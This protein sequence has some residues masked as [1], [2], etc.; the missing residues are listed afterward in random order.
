MSRYIRLLSIC[1][2]SALFI[3][4]AYVSAEEIPGIPYLKTAS[5]EQSAACP[6]K[7]SEQQSHV[8]AFSLL[9]PVVIDFTPPEVTETYPEEGELVRESRPTIRVCYRDENSLIDI[10]S[11][12]VFLDGTDMTRVSSISE[13]QL[14]FRPWDILQPGDHSITVILS[15]AVGN[16]SAPRTIH[17]MVDNTCTSSD[18]GLEPYPQ[19][20]NHPSDVN[21]GMFYDFQSKSNQTE[22][23][24]DADNTYIPLRHSNYWYVERNPDG[25]SSPSGNCLYRFK[26]EKLSGTMGTLS[27]PG[28]ELLNLSL[29]RPGLMLGTQIAGIKTQAFALQANPADPFKYS[30][31]AD[32]RIMGGSFYRDVLGDGRLTMSFTHLDGLLK[33]A[34]E[35]T[36]PPEGI[37]GSADSA[38]M[39]SKLIGDKLKFKAE[40]CQSRFINLTTEEPL[41][42]HDNAWRT[43]LSGDG[44][45]LNWSLASTHLGP[46]FM[47]STTPASGGDRSRYSFNSGINLSPS[48]INF[49]V[50]QSRN[51]IENNELNPLADT[52]SGTVKYTYS[53]YGFPSFLTS[54]TLRTLAYVPVDGSSQQIRNLIQSLTFGT[55]YE[56]SKWSI[57]PTYTIKKIQD[58]SSDS[59]NESDTYIIKIAGGIKPVESLSVSP[60]FSFTNTFPEYTRVHCYTYQSG[61][62]TTLKLIPTRLDMNMAYSRQDSQA[63]DKSVAST[64]IN[65][66]GRLDWSLDR[67]IH[68]QI[69][70]SI[71]LGGQMTRSIDR[72][73]DTNSKEW[74]ISASI[75]IGL[76]ADLVSLSRSR[77]LSYR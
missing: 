69:S 30:S 66:K 4:C 33:N 39:E 22:A 76:P 65:A 55:S 11:I 2:L 75:N 13:E 67:Y 52:R 58:K 27:V 44:N 53:S 28:T 49:T 62:I 45:I 70:K 6:L 19:D 3:H 23:L 51:Y 50:F 1:L 37:S 68:D 63:E 7:V 29:Y 18:R 26:Y 38:L 36:P 17:F 59:R 20:M 8:A 43:Q 77:E 47:A 31:N 12:R 71:S 5:Q 57:S 73:S 48:F 16:M 54:Y 64:T 41:K 9:W 61:I 74:N 42:I 24:R 34:E 56:R 40:F 60:I 15:D 35:S 21:K 46:E 72:V 14:T 32:R 25:S 10:G